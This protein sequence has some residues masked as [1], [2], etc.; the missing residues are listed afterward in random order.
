VTAAAIVAVI[1]AVL[2]GAA[3]A[4]SLVAFRKTRSQQGMLERELARGKA[5]FDRI[6]A[7]ELAERGEQ[8]A[9]VLARARADTMS[10]LT[11]EERRIA[12]ERRRDVAERE[13]EIGRASCRERV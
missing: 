12:E 2:A 4:A 8:L 1:A 10:A 11:E 9:A 13:R 7:A 5:E 3:F 6:V